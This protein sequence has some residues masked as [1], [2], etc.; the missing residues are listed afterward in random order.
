MLSGYYTVLATVY[1]TYGANPSFG[2][3]LCA[4]RPINA[5]LGA[6]SAKMDVSTSDF[7][8]ESVT[9]VRSDVPLVQ[10]MMFLDI[11]FMRLWLPCQS[12]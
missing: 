3:K 4:P 9:F 2:P 7:W 10:S 8:R 6:Y 1:Y 11:M 12:R 5:F